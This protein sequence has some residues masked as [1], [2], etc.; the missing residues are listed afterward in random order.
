MRRTKPKS[1]PEPLSPEQELAALA[2]RI[3]HC[4]P[5]D[6]GPTFWTMAAEAFLIKLL[7]LG[8]HEALTHVRAIQS[9]PGRHSDDLGQMRDWEP[10]LIHLVL[11]HAEDAL[12]EYIKHATMNRNGG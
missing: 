6:L 9:A 8:L 12:A 7:P 10:K 4:R 3:A 11:A 2:H 1:R 5:P